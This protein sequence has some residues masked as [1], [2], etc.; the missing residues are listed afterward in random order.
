MQVT[1]TGE[2]DFSVFPKIGRVSV[3]GRTCAEVAAELKH[4]LEADYYYHADVSLGINRVNLLSSRGKV[5]LTGLVRAPG[6]QDLPVNEHVTV[7]SAIMRAGGFDKFADE[8]HVKIIRQTKDG[9]ATTLN[10]DVGS[11]IE[12]G[13]RE[14]DVELEDGD[15]IDVPQ[16]LIN[17]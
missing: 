6:A 17:F 10:V 13:H 15:Y 3:V 5:Y 8:K 7:S 14:R 1:D 16:R 11:I 9:R 4:R 2:L 12:K